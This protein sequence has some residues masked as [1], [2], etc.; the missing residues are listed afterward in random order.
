MSCVV[1]IKTYFRVFVFIASSLWLAGCLSAPTRNFEDADLL[2]DETA[3]PINWLKAES[4]KKAPDP[5]EE[6]EESGAFISFYFTNTTY[7]ARGGETIYHYNSKWRAGQNYDRFELTYFNDASV[8]QTTPWQM[9][10]GF[11]FASTTADKWRFACEG[12]NFTF[13]PE[14]GSSSTHCIYLARYS[15]FLVFFSIT[16][17]IDGQT[18]ITPDEIK[19]ILEALDQKMSDYLAPAK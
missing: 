14:A 12:S 7:F 8:Y 9:P 3:M 10:E 16:T 13:G 18:F 5:G 19:P 11:D 4:A 15:E 2:I 6:G 17:E 1:N